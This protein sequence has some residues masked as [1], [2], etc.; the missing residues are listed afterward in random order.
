M[1]EL[2]IVF[3][4]PVSVILAVNFVP[5]GIVVFGVEIHSQ[6][7]FPK[8]HSF[9]AELLAVNFINQSLLVN[10]L[11]QAAV[12][13]LVKNDEF[14]EILVRGSLQFVASDVLETHL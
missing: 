13:K 8:G 14:Q 2:S 1:I 7:F 6:Q 12:G 4:D 11:D 3:K 5:E 10:L 9:F